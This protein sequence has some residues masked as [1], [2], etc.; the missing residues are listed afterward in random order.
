[1]AIAYNKLWKLYWLIKKSQAELQKLANIAPNTMTKLHRDEAVNLAILNRVC[2]VLDC[3][4]GDIMDFVP[5]T[6]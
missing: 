4:I 6:K 2:E 3:N 5:K 1:M